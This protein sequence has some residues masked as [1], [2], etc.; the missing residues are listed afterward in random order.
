MNYYNRYPAHYVARTMHLT[1]EQDGAYN[2]LL[3]WCYSNERPVPHETRYA[4]ARAVKASER[5]AV[6]QILDEFFVR[7]GDGWTQHRVL[8][9]IEQAAPRIAAARANG[10]AGGR[11]KGTGGAKTKNPPGNPPGYAPENP[12]GFSD[13]TQWGTQDEPS[14]K[15]PHTPY[16]KKSEREKDAHAP[17]QAPAGEDPPDPPPTL[18]GAACLAMRRAGCVMTNPSH[19]DLVAALAEGVTPGMLADC[20][21]EAIERRIHAPFGW[22]IKTARGRHARGPEPTPEVPHDPAHRGAGRRP[23]A[24]EQVADAIRR[25]HA[26]DPHDDDDPLAAAPA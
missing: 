22:A 12:P 7:D 6:D 18:A 4:I 21:A 17:A 24:V 26:A 10:R 14:A 8:S 19:P 5:R 1:M 2:R 16:P 3:D 15:A 9:E 25:R 13:G 20:V 11:P 23:S